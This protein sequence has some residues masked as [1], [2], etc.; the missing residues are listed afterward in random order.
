VGGGGGGGGGG[1]DIAANS[2]ATRPAD[3]VGRRDSGECTFAKR[4]CGRAPSTTPPIASFPDFRLRATAAAVVAAGAQTASLQP[5]EQIFRCFSPVERSQPVPRRRFTIVGRSTALTSVR[6]RSR[7]RLR[8]PRGQRRTKCPRAPPATVD[9]L[10]RSR[11]RLQKHSCRSMRKLHARHCDR[12]ESLHKAARKNGLASSACA[13]RKKVAPKTVV[14]YDNIGLKL[15][16]KAGSVPYPPSH[17]QCDSFSNRSKGRGPRREVGTY[18]AP[19]KTSNNPA[20]GEP[21]LSAWF[22]FVDSVSRCRLP[23]LRRPGGDMSVRSSHCLIQTA[24]QASGRR[25]RGLWRGPG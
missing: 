14:P 22:N 23:S 25:L 5:S 12:I 6:H 1:G 8:S 11:A 19:N 7:S 24:R 2:S 4:G 10:Q 13:P 9:T 15:S 21:L 16:S 17:S 3:G 18:R 20:Y